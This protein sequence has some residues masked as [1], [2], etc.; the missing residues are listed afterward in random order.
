MIYKRSHRGEC[1]LQ[2]GG[3]RCHITDS[4]A[5]RRVRW[6]G[7]CGSGCL[8]GDDG[9]PLHLSNGGE[10]ILNSIVGDQNSQGFTSIV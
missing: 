8:G 2:G 4:S 10:F 9:E 1:L 5:Q 7:G 6:P 3:L